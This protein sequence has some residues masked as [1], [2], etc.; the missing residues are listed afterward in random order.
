MSRSDFSFLAPLLLPFFSATHQ[1]PLKVSFG[2]TRNPKNGNEIQINWRKLFSALPTQMVQEC[3][4]TSPKSAIFVVAA[5][6]RILK[7][8]DKV[9][10]LRSRIWFQTFLWWEFPLQSDVYCPRDRQL[11]SAPCVLC[12]NIPSGFTSLVTENEVIFIISSLPSLGFFLQGSLSL[13]I[14]DV[15]KLVP[16]QFPER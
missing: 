14:S 5:A 10:S 7:L 12:Q 9:P 15:I 3:F 2:G 1:T 13:S 4:L 6:L 8:W 16:C 11:H